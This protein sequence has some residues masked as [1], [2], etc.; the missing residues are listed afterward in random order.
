LL[1]LG[2]ITGN[3]SGVFMFFAGDGSEVSVGAAFRFRWAGLA[4]V[5]QSQVLGDAFACGFT[6][7]IR[8]IAPELLERF[9]LRA[10]VLVALSVPFK[11]SARSGAI[12]P[13]RTIK[14]RN[15]G[16]DVAINEPSQHRS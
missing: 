5:F 12:R 14:H 10:D 4:G 15:M 6:V 9:T 11:V 3:L 13:D 7:R 2:N 16:F 1:C 8:I